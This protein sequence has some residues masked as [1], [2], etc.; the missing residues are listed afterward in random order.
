[1]QPILVSYEAP[2]KKTVVVW[3]PYGPYW[4]TVFFSKDLSR[5]CQGGGGRPGGFCLWRLVNCGGP[6]GGFF[7]FF[8]LFYF[9]FLD[10]FAIVGFFGFF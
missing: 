4:T 7:S 5:V 1:M 2:F 6:A 10:H 9:I 3:G 8:F